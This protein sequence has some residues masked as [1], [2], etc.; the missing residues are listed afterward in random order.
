MSPLSTSS[1][2]PRRGGAQLWV[3]ILITGCAVGGISAGTWYFRS[4]DENLDAHA[5]LHQV[6][7]ERFEHY[8]NDRGE[9]ESSSNVE[10]RC[11]VKSRGTEGTRILKICPEGTHV[12]IGDFLVQFDDSLL[13]AELTQRE[14]T[15][16]SGEAA[17]IQSKS[18]LATATTALEEYEKGTYYQDLELAGSEVFVAEENLRRS[19]EYLQYS[20]RLA[21]KGYVTARQ[22]EADRFA[23]EKTRK[24][25]QAAQTKLDVL[26]RYTRKKTIG[27]LTADI[28]KAKAALKSAENAQKLNIHERDEVLDQISKCRVVAPEA[29]QVVYENDSDRRGDDEFI[30]KEG[31]IVRQGQTIIRL[32]DP[33]RMQVNAVVNET[34]IN[35]VKKDRPARVELVSR[36][37][38]FFDGVVRQI[39][40]FPIKERWNRSGPKKYNVIVEILN[41]P[42]NIRPGLRANVQIFVHQE[43]DALTVPIQSIVSRRD[44]TSYCLVREED[45]WLPRQVEVGPNNEKQVVIRDGL[46]FGEQVAVDPRTY[47]DQVELPEPALDASKV[48]HRDIAPDSGGRTAEKPAPG[49]TSGGGG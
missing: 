1:I 24:E 27:Q 17:V 37:G 32:P 21:A 9:I 28:A 10:V 39:D 40:A 35:Q 4:T 38:R 5:I 48:A 11:H 29:G 23:V 22:L 43:T 12:K 15:V 2:H 14:I 49:Q 46:L 47:L 6:S 45:R 36:P 34:R 13:Q 26:K 33:M 3:L 30:V 31:A 7:R 44:G 42:E 41:P 8:V 25:L 16:S 18:D 20:Q 19:E